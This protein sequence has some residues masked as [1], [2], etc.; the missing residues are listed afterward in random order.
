MAV[1]V[2]ASYG[3]GLNECMPYDV[4]FDVPDMTTQQLSFELR[5][6]AY[7]ILGIVPNMSFIL[8]ID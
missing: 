4:W 7:N 3:S 6:R 8:T 2:T 1:P 5:D